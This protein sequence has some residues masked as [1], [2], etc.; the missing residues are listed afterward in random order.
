MPRCRRGAVRGRALQPDVRA[1]VWMNFMN[2]NGQGARE[3][4]KEAYS[5]E[6]YERLLALKA[7][8]DP[9]NAFRSSYPLVAAPE[10]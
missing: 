10:R 4:I 7:K 8:Y 6:T 5:P 3:R 2:G 9:D 1:G